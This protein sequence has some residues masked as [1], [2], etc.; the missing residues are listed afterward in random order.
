[1]I[2]DDIILDDSYRV[3][4]NVRNELHEAT[5]VHWHGLDVPNEM[6]GPAGTQEPIEPGEIP[7]RVREPAGHVLLPL[8]PVTAN[9][10]SACTAPSSSPPDTQPLGIC[11]K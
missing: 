7:L 3:R 10:P 9:R 6:D 11:E 8:A 2:L 4:L 1:M 5:T